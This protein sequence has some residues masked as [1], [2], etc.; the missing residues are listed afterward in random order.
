MLAQQSD[1]SGSHRTLQRGG[2]TVLP[3]KDSKYY[4]HVYIFYNIYFYVVTM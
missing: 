3:N 1:G 2:N 4:T